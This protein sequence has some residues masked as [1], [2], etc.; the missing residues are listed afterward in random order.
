MRSCYF[1]YNLLSLWDHADLVRA[2]CKIITSIPKLPERIADLYNLPYLRYFNSL[3]L[4]SV[5]YGRQLRPERFPRS[6]NLWYGKKHHKLQVRRRGLCRVIG[7]VLE[8]QGLGIGLTGARE[9]QGGENHAELYVTR[10]YSAACQTC[11]IE[12]SHTHVTMFNASSSFSSPLMPLSFIVD[13][14]QW[15]YPACA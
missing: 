5:V 2:C 7:S 14:R 3:R 9:T 4:P 13:E 12:D 8:D 6:R 11:F 15:N 10:I 1:A